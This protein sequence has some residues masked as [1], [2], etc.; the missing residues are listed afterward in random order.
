MYSEKVPVQQVTPTP[1]NRVPAGPVVRA[2]L[3]GDWEPLCDVDMST[4][5]DFRCSGPAVSNSSL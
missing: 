4:E 1:N 3:L 5:N 2:R